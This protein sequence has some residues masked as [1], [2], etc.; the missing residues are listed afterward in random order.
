M[1]R[2]AAFFFAHCR[3]RIEA[4]ERQITFELSRYVS[5]TLK[6]LLACILLE[7]GFMSNGTSK[8]IDHQLEDR[9][10]FLLSIAGIVAQGGILCLL[11]LI[12]GNDTR[13]NIPIHLSR[14]SCGQDT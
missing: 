6:E 10:D 13:Q 8:V 1:S 12:N 5:L 3:V 2:S 7:E 11:T 4:D 14:E 9:L